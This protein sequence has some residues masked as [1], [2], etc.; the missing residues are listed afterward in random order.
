MEGLCRQP[1]IDGQSVTG[2][3]QTNKFARYLF[4]L[5]DPCRDLVVRITALSGEPDLFVTRNEMTARG[6]GGSPAFQSGLNWY[7]YDVGHGILTLSHRSRNFKTGLYEVVVT[8][9]EGQICP[10]RFTLLAYTTKLPENAKE[11]YSFVMKD[12]FASSFQNMRWYPFC[13]TTV[14]SAAEFNVTLSSDRGGAILLTRNV[15]STYAK[16]IEDIY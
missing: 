16:N 6:G 9:D 10:S 3:V 14:T 13:L 4:N 12:N 15:G 1:L 5:V 7:D 2:E 11:D 8:C